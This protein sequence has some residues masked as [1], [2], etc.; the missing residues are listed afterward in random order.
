MGRDRTQSWKLVS[1]GKSTFEE[2]KKLELGTWELSGPA[3]NMLM[4]V[5]CRL[6]DKSREYARRKRMAQVRYFNCSKC[7]QDA[8]GANR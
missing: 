3:H 5:W 8:L 6:V 4:W 7:R 2:L 1:V